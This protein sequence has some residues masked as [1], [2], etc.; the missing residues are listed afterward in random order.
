MKTRLNGSLKIL[1]M[2]FVIHDSRSTLARDVVLKAIKQY[3]QE[4]CKSLVGQNIKIEEAQVMRKSILSYA[5]E[6]RGS[7]QYRELGAELLNRM[8][9]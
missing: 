5:P 3:P 2:A 8:G 4:V 9:V 7:S 1:G 6:D